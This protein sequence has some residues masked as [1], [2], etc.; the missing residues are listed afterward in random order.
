MKER[1]ERTPPNEYTAVYIQYG[2]I[3]L[4]RLLYCIGTLL[5]TCDR[6]P[7]NTALHIHHTKD[8][9]HSPG[10]ATPSGPKDPSYRLPTNS[11]VHEHVKDTP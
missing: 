11:L 1:L 6:R 7:T 5:H 4:A 3:C 10:I 8:A 2:W 9:Y